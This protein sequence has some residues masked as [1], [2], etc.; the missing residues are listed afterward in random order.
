M[1]VMASADARA[2]TAQTPCTSME[3]RYAR[4]S[5]LSTAQLIMLLHPLANNRL[6][7]DED[8]CWALAFV[9]K[10]PYKCM[11]VTNARAKQLSLSSNAMVRRD[12]LPSSC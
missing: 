4:A 12:D 5:A 1:H 6:L 8:S 3:E 10:N 2:F 7:V 11:E 9:A